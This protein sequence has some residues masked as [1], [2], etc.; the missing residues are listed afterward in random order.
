MRP[1]SA[2]LFLFL[3]VAVPARATT[4][5]RAGTVAPEGTP[6]E[7]LVKRLAKHIKKDSGDA[8]KFKI[9]LGGQKG[10]EKSLVRQCKDG[11]LEFIGTSTAALATAVPDLQVLEL[12]FLF[13]SSEEAD[14]ILDNHLYEPVKKV[15]AK[16]GFILY[17][18]AE[19][20][21]QN[22]GLKDG[23]IKSPKDLVGRKMRSQES[24]V[25]LAMW[26]GF[27]ASPVEMGVSEVLPALKTGLVDGFGQTP[28]FTFAAGWHQGIKKYTVSHHV[29]QPA[30]LVYSKKWF[31]KQPKNLQKHLLAHIADDTEW[32]RKKVRAIEPGLIQNFTAYGIEMYEL[33][34]DERAVFAKVAE[35]IRKDFAKQTTPGG[36]KLL[37][38]IEK[39]KA[40]YKKVKTASK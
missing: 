31:D 16:H 12:P 7:R 1:C 35:K 15:L 11:R 9:F 18:W 25:H 30:I 14:Y 10:D 32:G 13:E 4:I 36:R 19:N 33:N 40:A 39:G 8:I 24:K 28:L 34:A 23:F 37:K 27:G 17:Q 3:A 22:F 21:W 20:G 5:V 2:V 38:A 6:W 29:Y 26:K